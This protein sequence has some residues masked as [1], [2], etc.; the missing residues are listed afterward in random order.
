MNRRLATRG[1]T[2]I[3]LLVVIAIIGVLIALLLPAIQSAREA[4]RRS[5]CANN[6]HQLGLAL[7]S[8]HAA[9]GMFPPGAIRGR[10]GV[11]GTSPDPPG[12]DAWG[13]WSLQTLLLPYMDQSSIYEKLNFN[14][15]SYRD[16]ASCPNGF[17]TGRGNS[18][19]FMTRINSFLCPTDPYNGWGTRFSLPFPGQNYVINLGD[20]SQFFA[21]SPGQDTRGPFHYSSRMGF[22]DIVDGVANTIA[23]AERVK[24][25][26]DRSK[27]AKGDVFGGGAAADNAPAWPS[28]QPRAVALMAP[29]T[30][31]TWISA[32]NTYAIARRGTGRHYVHGGRYWVVGHYTYS[33]F[34][35]IHTPNSPNADCFNGGCGEFDC[36]GV[37]T[38]SSEHPGGANVLML[39][40]RVQF[41][42]ES[43]DRI[44]WWGMG[45][46]NGGEAQSTRA[47]AL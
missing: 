31:D 11:P 39:D 14:I 33:F 23:M 36:A 1:F 27:R 21:E 38:A 19:G 26:N 30:L 9:Y 10:C 5:Q 42:T 45:S 43:I 12:L 44:V 17:A 6:L 18:T 46:R 20:T 41:V 4:S 25:S 7:N 34:N 15:S 2:L 13:S 16:D 29:G 37:Y 3:E 24:G 32:C 40:A 35:T 47:E 8:Y 22:R 28:G